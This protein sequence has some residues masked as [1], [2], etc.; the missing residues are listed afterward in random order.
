MEPLRAGELLQVVQV[1]KYLRLVQLIRQQQE[2]QRFWF[3]Q[4][5][6]VAEAVEVIVAQAEPLVVVAAVERR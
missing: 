6:V 3:L 4:L 2:S 5:V 1:C